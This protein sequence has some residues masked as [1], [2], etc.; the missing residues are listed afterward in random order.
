MAGEMTPWLRTLA[1]LPEGQVQIPAS[2]VQFQGIWHPLLA[3]SGIRYAC[4]AQFAHSNKH[5]HK[6]QSLTLI[7]SFYR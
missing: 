4:G 6:K 2:A 7:F 5:T 3:F 1:T